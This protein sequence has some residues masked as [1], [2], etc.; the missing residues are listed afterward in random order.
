VVDPNGSIFERGFQ[1]YDN[2]VM[3]R[4]SGKTFFDYFDNIGFPELQTQQ[5]DL[6][7]SSSFPMDLFT[8]HLKP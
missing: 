7:F 2:P 4:Q 5:N 3:A 8:F 1:C 6:S